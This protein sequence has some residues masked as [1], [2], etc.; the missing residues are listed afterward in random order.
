MNGLDAE[1][2]ERA[3]RR[4]VA[5][6]ARHR[7]DQIQVTGELAGDEALV[8]PRDVVSLLAFILTQAAQGRGVTVMP[9]QAEL[10]TQQAA[11]CLN[12][13]RPYLIRLLEEGKIPHR[14]VG[15]HRRVRFEDLM[16]YKR[17]DDAEQRAN[18][19]EIGAIGQ[20]LG[21]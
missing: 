12:V 10:T 5:Y 3:K 4:L 13:S 14:L 20:E 17:R 6:L 9:M 2:A 21:I 16:D 15:R 1:V 8:L 19:D 11:D 18:L 7:E